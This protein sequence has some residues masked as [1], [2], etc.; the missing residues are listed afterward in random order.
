[1]IMVKSRPMLYMLNENSL[2]KRYE[3]VLYNIYICQIGQ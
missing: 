2:P 3:I 1:M